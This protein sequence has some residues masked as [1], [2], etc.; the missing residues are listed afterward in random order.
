MKVYVVFTE[1]HFRNLAV[2]FAG[3]IGYFSHKNFVYKVDCNLCV[4]HIPILCTAYTVW[5]NSNL[6]SK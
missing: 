4:S 3:S 6:N 1:R 2:A 5:A